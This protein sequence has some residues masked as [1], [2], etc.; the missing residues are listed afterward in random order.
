MNALFSLMWGII[1]IVWVFAEKPFIEVVLCFLVCGVFS[2]AAELYEL[3]K[4]FKSKDLEQLLFKVK[5]DK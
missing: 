5:G 3:R 4:E 2:G 1:G